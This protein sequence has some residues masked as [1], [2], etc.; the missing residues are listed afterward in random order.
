MFDLIDE[1]VMVNLVMFKEKFIVDVFKEVFDFGDEDD[2]DKVVCEVFV[3]EYKDFM[4]WMKVTFG[5]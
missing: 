2:V 1:V 4:D 3:E 5:E